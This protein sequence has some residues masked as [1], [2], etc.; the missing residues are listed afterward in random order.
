[1]QVHAADLLVGDKVLVTEGARG[2]FSR[3]VTD[4]LTVAAAPH[5]VMVELLD[6]ALGRFWVTTTADAEL[7]VQR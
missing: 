7:T 2:T 4:V 3:T 1:M 6:P 5:D